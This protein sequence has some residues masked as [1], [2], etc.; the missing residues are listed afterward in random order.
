MNLE[1]TSKKPLW[2][3]YGKPLLSTY[4]IKFK[5]FSIIIPI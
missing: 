2:D 4:I 3:P 1:R 5:Y